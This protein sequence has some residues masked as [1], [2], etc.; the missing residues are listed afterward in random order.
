MI[1]EHNENPSKAVKVFLSA[2]V[3]EAHATVKTKGLGKNRAP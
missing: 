2:D 1:L 3:V